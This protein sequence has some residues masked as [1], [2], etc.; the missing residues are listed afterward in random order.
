M[1]D[2]LDIKSWLRTFGIAVLHIGRKYYNSRDLVVYDELLLYKISLSTDQFTIKDIDPT[3]P[4]YSKREVYAIIIAN[5][6][7][8]DCFLNNAVHADSPTKDRGAALC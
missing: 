6:K 2:D 3:K 5:K 4:T 1:K 8:L 7:A